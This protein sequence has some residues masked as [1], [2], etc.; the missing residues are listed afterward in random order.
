[1]RHTPFAPLSLCPFVPLSYFFLFPYLFSVGFL[2]GPIG[3]AQEP[4]S[5]FIA[6]TEP[7]A[8]AQ[9]QKKFHLPAGFEIQLVAA[10]PD[11]R[12]PVNLNFDAKGR[13]LVSSS[14]EYPFPAQPGGKPRD[15]LKLLTDTDHDGRF[16]EL[17]TF[18]DGLNIPVGVTPIPSGVMGYSVPNIYRFLDQ[19]GDGRADRRELVYGS[20]GFGDTHGM[21]SSFTWWI[22]GWVY[23]CHGESNTATV[24]GADGTALKLAG[25]C[26]FRMRPDGSH[27]ERFTHGQVN[28]FGLCFDPLGNVYTADSHSKPATMLL[29]GAWYPGLGTSHDGLGFGPQMMRHYHGSTGIAGIAYYAADHFPA[30]YQHTLFIG[31]PATGRINHDRLEV[32]GSTYLAIEQPDFLT[33]DDP[34]F[35]P[36][37]VQL[38]PDGALYIADFYNRII[39]HTLVPLGHAKRDRERGRIWRV[40]YTGQDANGK[41]IRP[42]PDLAKATLTELIDF[43][44]DPNLVVRTHATHQLA[45]RIGNAAVDPIKR[46]FGANSHPWQ[47]AHGLWVLQ[48]LGKL[49]EK[50]IRRLA[51]DADRRVRVHLLKALAERP[52]WAGETSAIHRLVKEKLSD[53]D[54][55][56]RRAAAEA[57]A[58]HPS[59]ANIQPLLKLWANTAEEDTLLIHTARMALRDNLRVPGNILQTAERFSDRPDFQRRLADVSLGIRTPQAAEFIFRHLQTESADF[60][61]LGEFLHHAARYL[62]VARLPKLYAFARTFQ[63]KK[64]AVQRS[65]LRSL[66]R[67]AEERGVELPEEI[68]TWGL[69]MSRQLLASG[70]ERLVFAGIELAWDLKRKELGR[71]LEELAAKTSR[72]KSLRSFA[73]DALGAVDPTRALRVLDCVLSDPSE[74]L[75]IQQQAA[76]TLGKIHNDQSRSVLNRHLVVAPAPLALVI[77]RQLSLSREG[78]ELL[79]QAVAGG[80]ASARLLQDGVVEQRLR[81]A[82]PAELQRRLSKLL[83]GLPREDDRLVRIVNQ[84][85]AGYAKA[86]VNPKRGEN[87]FEKHCRI[88]HQIGGRGETVG[89]QLDGIGLRGLERILEDTLDPNRNVDQKFRSSVIVLTSGRIVTGLVL[90]D[91]GGTIVVVDAAGKNIHIPRGDVEDRRLLKLSSMPAD[92][93][94]IIPEADFYHLVA[95]LLSQRLE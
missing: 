12:K 45:E 54:A 22:D 13:L 84:R 90:S 80:K 20:F 52:D 76:D 91:E 30:T 4:Y 66:H 56:V 24:A 61:R 1:M 17:K 44:R 28:P 47:R 31:N 92:A 70:E 8:P 71:E 67:A 89:P 37:D 57:F 38:G 32:H 72:Q 42:V 5:R 34:W 93:A 46:L 11:V 49:D 19:D 62:D 18:A 68:A 16:E 2:A 79:L 94:E 53:P 23:A 14:V 9:Q 33:C 64:G 3:W 58:S 78:A 59:P 7:L 75:E 10:E 77:A 88:C 74:P 41:R 60:T 15:V 50:S 48:R 81:S 95:Y 69:E 86:D 39:A 40:V 36:V 6:R 26:T 65:V 35:R 25:G 83:N 73:V 43:L 55:F 29:R 27:I 51:G 21:P 82:E 87:V 63:G 85:R